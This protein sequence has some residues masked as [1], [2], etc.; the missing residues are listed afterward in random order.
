MIIPNELLLDIDLTIRKL[1]DLKYKEFNYHRFGKVKR[2]RLP[3]THP[4][5]RGLPNVKF[6]TFRKGPVIVGILI[7]ECFSTG[8]RYVSYKIHCGDIK[9]EGIGLEDLRNRLDNTDELIKSLPM[10]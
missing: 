3:G 1:R 10:G 8:K 7:H 5:D 2:T 6:R 9:E 4:N